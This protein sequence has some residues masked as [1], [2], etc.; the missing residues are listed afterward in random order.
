MCIR[1]SP[2]QVNENI[3][4]VQVKHIINNTFYSWIIGFGGIIQISGN[5]EQINRFKKYLLDNFIEN[6]NQ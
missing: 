6:D 3:Y 2:Y 1:D 4:R 5:A